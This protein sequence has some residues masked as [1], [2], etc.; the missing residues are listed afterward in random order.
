MGLPC[1]DSRQTVLQKEAEREVCKYHDHPSFEYKGCVFR[2]ISNTE[3]KDYFNLRYRIFCQELEWVPKNE[4]KLEIDRYDHSGYCKHIG[5]FLPSGKIIACMRLILPSKNG[6][7]LQN[8]LKEF[9]GKSP[10][11]ECRNDAVE[12]T[13]LGIDQEFRDYGSSAILLGLYKFIYQW[14]LKNKIFKWYFVTSKKFILF[15]KRFGFFVTIIGDGLNDRN[16]VFTVPGVIDLG[17]SVEQ[18]KEKNITR[19]NFL[20]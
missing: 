1:T 17:R 18:L 7:M 8:E 20:S 9:F 16:E 4:D 15:L 10:I 19:Y 13:R 14:S 5:S 11:P 6:W 3:I 12:I 2:K